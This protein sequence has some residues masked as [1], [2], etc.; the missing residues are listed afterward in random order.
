MSFKIGGL[1][2]S[3]GSSSQT[4]NNP[5]LT[6]PLAAQTKAQGGSEYTGGKIT[7]SVLPGDTQHDIGVRGLKEHAKK[8]GLSDE[9][10]EGGKSPAQLFAEEWADNNLYARDKNGLR[11]WDETKLNAVKTDGSMTF[12][13]NQTFDSKILADLNSR[14]AILKGTS[15]EEVLKVDTN[16]ELTAQERAEYQQKLAQ[17]GQNKAAIQEKPVMALIDG[18]TSDGK[19]IDAE[20]ALSRYIQQT[21][22]PKPESGSRRV[23]GDKINEMVSQAKTDGVNIDLKFNEDGTAAVGVSAA[24]KQKLDA[25]FNDALGKTILGEKGSEKAQ[26]EETG[27]VVDIPIMAGNGIINTVNH[28]TEP[29]RGTLATFGVD[30]SGAKIPKIPYQ[31][32]YGKKN[33]MAG[34][35]GTEIGFGIVT[36]P[37]L[38]KT[39]AGKVLFGVDGAY[40]VAAGAAGVDPTEKDAN[41]KPREMGTV[42]RGFRIVG[43][44][45]EVLGARPNFETAAK[46]GTTLAQESEVVEA[47]TPDGNTVRVQVPKSDKPIQTAE[48]LQLYNKSASSKTNN[49]VGGAYK[50]VATVKNGVAGEVHHMPSN[51]SSPLS[52]DHGPAIW[53]EKADHMRTASWGRGGANYQ[54]QQRALIEQG[55]FREA[56]EMDVRDIRNLFGDKYDQGINEMLKYVDELE[57]S[58]KTAVA[59]QK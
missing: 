34:E 41:G 39:V 23:W 45:G 58:G 20:T 9:A 49:A 44:A 57:K 40:N 6:P 51:I 32:E 52:K 35:I 33:G 53:M 42:E 27:Q 31:S 10:P 36:A 56:V 59:A 16:V 25:L 5:A 1:L 30:T 24:D 17:A 11:A 38:L 54:A 18:R 4:S 22:N 2:S 12:T 19:P 21:Y 15:S 37:S 8:A 47:L 14:V 13:L 43:G 3:L 55:R 28:V 29:V 50:D 48:D 46:T 7:I 26:R